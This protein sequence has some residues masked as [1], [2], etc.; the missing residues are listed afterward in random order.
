[1]YGPPGTGKVFVSSSL[2]RLIETLKYVP[3]QI[4]FP[5]NLPKEK[6]KG[7]FMRICILQ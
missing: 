6:K 4:G 5:F 2:A 3:V 1:M 7:V